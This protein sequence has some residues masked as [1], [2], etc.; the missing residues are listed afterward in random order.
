MKPRILEIRKGVLE[1]NDV[2]AG[3]LRQRFT[4]A[5]VLVLNLVSSPGAGK[6]AFL[7]YTLRA[8]IERGYGVAALVG[9]LETEND[10]QRLARSGAAVRGLRLRRASERLC[11]APGRALP[12]GGAALREPDED[13]DSRE[14]GQQAAE[15]G[16]ELPR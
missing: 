10:A 5:G 3:D 2:I 6:T 13:A 7:E 9:D 12:L 14:Q 11:A 4:A 15:D 8:L 16:Q 1:K